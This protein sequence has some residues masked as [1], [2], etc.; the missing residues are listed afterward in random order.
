MTSL[1]RQSIPE[2]ATVVNGT[3][4]DPLGN[5][6]VMASGCPNCGKG[7]GWM[8][9]MTYAGRKNSA[10][11][12]QATDPDGPCSRACALQVEYAEGLGFGDP[13]KDV[14]AA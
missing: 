2:G 5:P 13:Q 7:A 4:I 14:P 6:Y 10:Q 1:D 9:P 3:P 11:I 8:H 12:G